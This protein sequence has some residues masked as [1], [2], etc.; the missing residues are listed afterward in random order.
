MYSDELLK[1]YIVL[2]VRVFRYFITL[3]QGYENNALY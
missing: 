3:L 2:L 1:G